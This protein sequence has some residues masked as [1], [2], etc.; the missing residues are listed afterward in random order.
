VQAYLQNIY[1]LYLSFYCG[2]AKPNTKEKEYLGEY[3]KKKGDWDKSL[4]TGSRR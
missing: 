3:P 2:R 4:E 1:Q